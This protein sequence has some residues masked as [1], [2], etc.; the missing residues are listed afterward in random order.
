MRDRFQSH[1]A[2]H[3]PR[4]VGKKNVLI[5]D[6]EEVVHHDGENDQIVEDSEEGD[7]VWNEIKGRKKEGDHP[8]ENFL[9]ALRDA[10]VSGRIEE[11]ISQVL[12]EL[13]GPTP[14][15]SSRIITE[16]E[17]NAK[18]PVTKLAEPKPSLQSMFLAWPL[19][20]SWVVHPSAVG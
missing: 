8:E 12:Q 1:E 9:I 17:T 18:A 14:F 6:R 3:S 10:R 13:H 4:V 5:E 15:V 20:A 16:V 7:P 19:G 11:K 2:F